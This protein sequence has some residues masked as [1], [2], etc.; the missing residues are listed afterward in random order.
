M[1]NLA[2]PEGEVHSR[3][4]DP[5][6]QESG[7]GSQGQAWGLGLAGVGVFTEDSRQGC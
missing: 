5:P 7:G 3:W 2:L 1:S 4:K 6:E